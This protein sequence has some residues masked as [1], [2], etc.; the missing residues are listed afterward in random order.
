MAASGVYVTVGLDK[1]GSIVEVIVNGEPIKYRE[2][3]QGPSKEGDSAPGC[4]QIV[5]M[6]VHELLTCRKKTPPGQPPPPVTDPCCI[7]DPA[8]GRIW[9]WC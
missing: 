4:E 2:S 9:C 5:K 7:R 6:L 1:S 3:R 8:T